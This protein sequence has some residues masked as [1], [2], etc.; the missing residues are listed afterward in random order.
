VDAWLKA[1]VAWTLPVTAALHLAR[2][3]PYRLART[4]E[5]LVLFVHDAL[6][7]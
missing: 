5:A 4:R 3:D 6:S 2:G 1:H 7:R